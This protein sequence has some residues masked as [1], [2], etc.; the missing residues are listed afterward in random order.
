VHV[1]CRERLRRGNCANLAEK[2]ACTK[3]GKFHSKGLYLK[4]TVM[5]R[6]RV[7]KRARLPAGRAWCKELEEGPGSRK[8]ESAMHVPI[9]VKGRKQF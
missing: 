1:G 2:K 4:P 5:I 8:N 6:K 7:R 3:T 9:D